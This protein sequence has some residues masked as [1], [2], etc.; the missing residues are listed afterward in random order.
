MKKFLLA[1]TALVAM[2]ASAQAATLTTPNDAGNGQRGIMFDVTTGAQALTFESLA[3]IVNGAAQGF[4]F[5]AI[6]G[7][8]GANVSNGAA[9]TLRDSFSG[10]NGDGSSFYS[11]NIADFSVA[12]NSTI[13]FYLTSTGDGTIRYRNGNAVGDIRA[14]DGSLSILTGYGKDYPFSATF[15]PRDYV[16]SIT[17]RLGTG[18]VPEPATWTM[19]ILGFGVAGTAMRAR[20]K[21]ARLGFAF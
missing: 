18:A 2:T 8:I 15:A 19:L 17:Y 10:F 4:E 21:Q 20:R 14:T 7:G 1:A 12:A 5:Y 6:N 13:G 9:W 11:F 16:G 3:V